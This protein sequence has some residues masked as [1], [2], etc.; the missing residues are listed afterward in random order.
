MTWVYGT[1]NSISLPISTYR[2]YSAYSYDPWGEKYI[3]EIDNYVERNS[4]KEP[5]Y[6]RMDLSATFTNDSG[7]FKKSWNISVYNIYNR[8]NPFYLYFDYD[9]ND[10]RVLKQLSLFPILPSVSYSIKF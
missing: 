3:T 9:D 2:A 5:S 8:K 6:H 4:F 7:K 10:E 1:G